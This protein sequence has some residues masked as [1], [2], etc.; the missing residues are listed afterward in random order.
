MHFLSGVISLLVTLGLVPI[1][2]KMGIKFGIFDN[3]EGDAL[4]IHT[5][6]IPN[7][8]GMVIFAAILIGAMASILFVKT[9]LGK[10]LGTLSCGVVV[11]GLG[12]WDDLR[13]KNTTRYKPIVKFTSQ[14]LV[15]VLAGTLLFVI[16]VRNQFIPMPAVMGALAALYVFGSVNAV[17]MQ[18][19]IDGL[20]SGL[21]AISAAGFIALSV[22][23]GST[24][25][26]VMSLSTLGAVLGFLVYNFH[27]ASIF[28]GDSG[29]HLLGFMLALLAIIFTSKPYDIRWFIGPILIIGLPIF[30]A[31][32]AVMRRSIRRKPL[33]EGDRGHVYDRMMHR[34]LS[35]KQTVLICY[36]IQA[37]FVGSG[38]ALTRL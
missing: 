8:G 26:L 12:L 38:I 7:L 30:D 32:W 33:F 28:M 13:W 14:V 9:N 22:H 10:L 24:L 1:A 16:G 3:P 20:A 25:G 34:G 17:N 18:D 35:V 21:V 37:I 36:F 11:F 29:S 5:Q 19:G 31:A 2:S 6:P 23:T 27:P 15:S 4:K